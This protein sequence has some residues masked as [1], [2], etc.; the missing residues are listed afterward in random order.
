MSLLPELGRRHNPPFEQEPHNPNWS[1][2]KDFL[3][4][5]KLEQSKTM[6]TGLFVYL[7]GAYHPT[8]EFFTHIE[9]SPFP[10]KGCKF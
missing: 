9:M 5:N 8:Q 4:I 6:I 3:A 7:F 2:E 10:V 1:S